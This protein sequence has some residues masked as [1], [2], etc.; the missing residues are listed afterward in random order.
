MKP[1]RFAEWAEPI[2]LA[3]PA[4]AAVTEHEIK[5]I[6]RLS[7]VEF[8]TGAQI[9]IQW[10]GTAP[11]TGGG[12]PGEGDRVV[13]GQPPAPVK[14]PELATSGRLR[15]RDIEQ[16]LAA[17]LNN[18]GHEEIL[19]VTGYSQDPKLGSETQPYGI[20]I[21]FHDDSTVYAYFRRMAPAGGQ[22]GGDFQQ[23]EE[24]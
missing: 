18:G 7:R 12:A 6:P 1:R 14:I 2:L 16:H 11:P 3:S 23:R 22:P 24:V 21:R 17:L 10:A 20:R 4:I 13:T 5:D 9:I 15:T 8:A 19:D